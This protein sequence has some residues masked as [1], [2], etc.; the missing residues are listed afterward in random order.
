VGVILV[1]RRAPPAQG[2]SS[3]N[4][5]PFILSYAFRPPHRSFYDVVCA[6]NLISLIYV[7]KKSKSFAVLKQKKHKTL[8]LTRI[9]ECKANNSLNCILKADEYR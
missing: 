9:L 3:G 8:N 6:L 7:I 4:A 1:R 2:P 5:S